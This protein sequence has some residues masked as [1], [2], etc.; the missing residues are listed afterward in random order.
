[1]EGRMLF[2]YC[3]ILFYVIFLIGCDTLS[4]ISKSAQISCLPDIDLLAKHIRRYPQKDLFSSR[5]IKKDT[6]YTVNI[7]MF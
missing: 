1:M 5:L 4:G 2:C 3:F 6:F 7:F